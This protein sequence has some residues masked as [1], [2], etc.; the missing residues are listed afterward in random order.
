LGF[1]ITATPDKKS[2][3]HASCVESGVKAGK[4]RLEGII[5]PMVTPLK[6]PDALDVSGLERL[7]EHIVAGG[8]QGVFI[9]GTSGEGPGLSYRLRREVIQRTCQQMRGRLPILVGIT[10]TSF[11]EA[12]SM[13]QYAADAGAQ[14]VVTA[15]PYYLP[16]A[17][18]ELIDYVERLVRELPLPLFIYNMPQLTKVHF[19]PETLRRLTPLEKI[20][21][22]KDS[23]G[24]L[25]YFDK[26]VRLK[27]ERPDWS[28]FVGPEHLLVESVQRG[29]DGGVNGGAN[30]YP[31]LFVEL[32]QA[33]KT[34]DA[35]RA[36]KLQ[37]RL[38]QL[39]QIYSVGRHA[40]AVVKGMK[41]ACALLGICEDHMAEPF[42]R[43]REPEREK[44]RLI[45]QSLDLRP[46]K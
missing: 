23:S 40:S 25:G 4:L 24:D 28:V 6:G 27:C 2:G 12:V 15:G 1:V 46:I 17:Q 41:C 8:V 21:G 3:D 44:I 37:R 16:A 7:V 32:F 5:P 9:L 45:L 29:G 26:L 31:Q 42:D 20:V 13:A 36:E 19:E 43:F 18:P 35:A 33:V 14:A 22:L 30:F 34:G 11:T 10:D 39:G 38:L